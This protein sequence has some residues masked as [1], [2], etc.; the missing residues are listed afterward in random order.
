[1]TRRQ[2]LVAAAAAPAWFST[3]A[4]AQPKP[5]LG[6][7][8]APAGFGQQ[9]RALRAQNPQADFADLCHFLGLSGCE[10]RLAATDADTVRKLRDRSESL[11]LRLIL[12]IPLPRDTNDVDRFDSAVKAA[13]D[14]GAVSLHAALTQRR[15]EQFDAFDAFKQAFEQHQ[16]AVALAEPVL[17]KHRLRLGLENHKG[18]RAAEQA[19]WLKR[20][21][22]EW[23]GVHFDFGNN[24]ALCE[25]PDQTF[26]LL[27]PL[28]VACHIKDMAVQPYE[29]GFLLSEV[30]LGEGIID[31]KRWVETLR[32]RDP[33]MPFDLETITRDP[34]KIPVFT[35]K[36]WATFDDSYSPLPGRDLA[37]VLE[38]VHKN[39]PK[40]PLPHMTGLSPDQQ[41]KLEEE[42]NAKS[43][44]YAR[45]NLGL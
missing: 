43:I 12:D 26:A 17:R 42:A 44:E 13:K 8:G 10:L 24:L 45:Q 40:K 28:A 30:P 23:V 25:D 33:A 27:A 34:L 6:L 22:S 20:L 32:R 11:D 2:L 7:G 1:M 5:R 21:S 41:A 9:L 14:A 35:K 4:G 15:Y 16:K 18:W 38:I 39:P 31:L 36:Y 19:A 3:R 37:R 29:D